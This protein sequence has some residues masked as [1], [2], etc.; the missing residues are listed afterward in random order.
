MMLKISHLIRK[1]KRIGHEFVINREKPLQPTYN[2]TKDV[3]FGKMVHEWVPIERTFSHFDYVEVVI[4]ERHSIP[5][6][7]SVSWL[8]RFTI[9]VFANDVLYC[10]QF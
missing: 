9:S 1:Q 2:N 6:Q 7:S 5:Q 3:L 8:I 10:V 4:S